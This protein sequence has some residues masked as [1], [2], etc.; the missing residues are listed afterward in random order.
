MNIAAMAHGGEDRVQFHVAASS[1]PLS[2]ICP[3]HREVPRFLL[4]LD[5]FNWSIC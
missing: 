2:D 5:R 4:V 3:N 1:E